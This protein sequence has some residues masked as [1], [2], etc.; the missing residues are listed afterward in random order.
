MALALGD[1]YPGL[2]TEPPS[3]LLDLCAHKKS[4]ISYCYAPQLAL[5][6]ITGDKTYFPRFSQAY[7]VYGRTHVS[8]VSLT[9]RQE[10]SSA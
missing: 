4:R 2:A 8:Q 1:T 3:G 10:V 5:Y 7:R 9:L 6:K